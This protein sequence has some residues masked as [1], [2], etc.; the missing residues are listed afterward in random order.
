MIPL[1][2]ID[3]ASYSFLLSRIHSA[4]TVWELDK[5]SRSIK[6]VYGERDRGDGLSTSQRAIAERRREL[7]AQG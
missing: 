5:L 2:G 6:A 7:E 1:P 4:E 3:S